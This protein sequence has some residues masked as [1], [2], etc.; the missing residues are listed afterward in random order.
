MKKTALVLAIAIVAAGWFIFAHAAT[1]TD[2]FPSQE[3]RIPG[4]ALVHPQADPC[5]PA[6]ISCG[7]NSCTLPP[8]GVKAVHVFEGIL[9]QEKVRC[10]AQLQLENCPIGD[11]KGTRWISISTS[12]RSADG[13]CELLAE[14]V[15]SGYAVSARIEGSQ[16]DFHTLSKLVHF[17]ANG[18]GYFSG[19]P[20]FSS[21]EGSATGP[22]TP[23][24]SDSGSGSSGGPH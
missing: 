20:Y 16:A 18:I 8:A 24:V 12:L 9:Q 2:K 17:W 11:G 10:R 14:A 15:T 3:T 19:K 4:T 23:A 21:P 5:H 7:E 13:I 6:E 22:G 1:V